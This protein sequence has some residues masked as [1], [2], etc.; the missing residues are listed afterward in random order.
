M[1]ISASMALEVATCWARSNVWF[2]GKYCCLQRR[3]S[4]DSGG[5]IVDIRY[6]DKFQVMRLLVT[7]D[8]EVRVLK[9]RQADVAK[10]AESRG[11]VL[12]E[13]FA[14][15]EISHFEDVTLLRDA[16]EKVRYEFPNW[17]DNIRIDKKNSRS[18]SHD[19]IANLNGKNGRSV[20]VWIKVVHSKAGWKAFR[21][22]IADKDSSHI[23]VF[24]ICAGTTIDDLKLALVE[25]LRN[26]QGFLRL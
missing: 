5:R 22:R 26:V 4:T 21:K 12:P 1:V 23:I 8:F 9:D 2:K 15:L 6:L 3:I 17:L 11:L 13:K 24:M 25:K 20:E 7:N 10:I 14:D 16:V 18:G 19:I